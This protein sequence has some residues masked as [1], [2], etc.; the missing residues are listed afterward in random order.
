MTVDQMIKKT[1]AGEGDEDARPEWG[2]KEMSEADF[3]GVKEF[4]LIVSVKAEW[5]FTGADTSEEWLT[6]TRGDGRSIRMPQNWRGVFEF[7]G[8]SHV[9]GLFGETYLGK[10]MREQLEKIDK[11]EKKNAAD[12]REFERLKAKFGPAS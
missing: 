2:F 6:A 9:P 5:K 10:R 12:R 3:R 1:S 11:W 4:G 8:L 7:V